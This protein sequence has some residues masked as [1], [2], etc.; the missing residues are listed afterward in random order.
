M[1]T[2]AKVALVRTVRDRYGLQP[3]LEVLGLPRST[4]YYHTRRRTYAEKYTHLKEPLEAIAESHP[5]YGYR[6]TTPEL[7]E[8]HGFR[9]NRK[10]V[11][12]LHQLWDLPLRRAVRPPKPSGVRQAIQ[13]AGV[14]ANLLLERSKAEIGPLEVLYTDFTELIYADGAAKAWGMPIL[15]H[16]TKY[17]LGF[18]VGGRANSELALATWEEAKRPLAEWKPLPEGILVHHDQDPVFTGYAWTGQL[19][20]DGARISYALRGA[21]DNPEMESFIGRFK[22]ENRSLLL[23]AET[24]DELRAVIE[25]RTRYYNQERRHSSLGNRAPLAFIEDL[26]REG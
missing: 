11:Q 9:V 23:D 13:V 7:R 25:T 1:T 15:D 6:R 12:R 3:A 10:V 26:H 4:W 24:L 17:A 20:R 2:K 21:H 19:L 16:T 14:R 18:G 8:T 5:G 22:V